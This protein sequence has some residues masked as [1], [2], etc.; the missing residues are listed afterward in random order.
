M[1]RFIAWLKNWTNPAGDHPSASG[2]NLL[3]AIEILEPR[4]MLAT[5]SF[6]VF[7]VLET[8]EQ[9]HWHVEGSMLFSSF[10][11]DDGAIAGAESDRSVE[12]DSREFVYL[13]ELAD[14]IGDLFEIDDEERWWLNPE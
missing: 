3:P 14:E 10:R 13:G 2:R 6:A 4:Q 5:G 9:V 11:P 1:S 8:A 12:H 7:D